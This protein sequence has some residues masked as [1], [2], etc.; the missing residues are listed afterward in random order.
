MPRREAVSFRFGPLLSRKTYQAPLLPDGSARAACS[1]QTGRGVRL[2]LHSTFRVPGNSRGSVSATDIR[3]L[4]LLLGDDQALE[5]CKGCVSLEAHCCKAARRR[6]SFLRCFPKY[7]GFKGMHQNAE[8]ARECFAKHTHGNNAAA[9]SVAGAEQPTAFNQGL[10][11]LRALRSLLG[12]EER[13][14]SP[15]TALRSTTRKA[16]CLVGYVL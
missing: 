5:G 7:I 2:P 8:G 15:K 1:V 14:G 11:A 13:Q 4:R 3:L 6:L 10:K 9:A 16:Q 12:T